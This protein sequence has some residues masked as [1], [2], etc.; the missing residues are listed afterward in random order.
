MNA[1]NMT[2]D[3]EDEL[4]VGFILEDMPPKRRDGIVKRLTDG[5]GAARQGKELL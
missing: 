5:A 2:P 4:I 3:E 1:S